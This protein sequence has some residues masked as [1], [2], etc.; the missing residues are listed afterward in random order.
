MAGITS[1]SGSSCFT[2][3]TRITATKT[4]PYILSLSAIRAPIP[5]FSQPRHHLHYG[6]PRS[7]GDS[8]RPRKIDSGE[9]Q[10]LDKSRIR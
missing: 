7:Y 1:T 5:H 10:A 3:L 2:L 6:G 4:A 9:D 8:R